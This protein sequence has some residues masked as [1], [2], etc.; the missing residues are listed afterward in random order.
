MRGL[1]RGSH[2]AGLSVHNQRIERL[3]RDIF[4]HVL[5]LYYS[6]FYF[7]EDHYELDCLSDVDLF[8]LH[9]VYVPIINRAL[10]EF[11]DAYNRH[12]LRTEHRW[13][14]LMIW[15]NGLISPA[16]ASETAVQDFVNSENMEFF[17]VDPEGPDLND[18]DEGNVQVPETRVDLTEE[19]L[20]ELQEVDPLRISANYGIDIYLRVRDIIRMNMLPPH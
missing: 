12:A 2:I 7:L 16:H 5:Q 6:I 15:T 11:S 17:G 20:Q 4:Q 9:Y 8:A 19:G 3:W 14:P 1:E 10:R 18:F 13:T